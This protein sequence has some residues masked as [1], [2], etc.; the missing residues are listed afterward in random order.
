MLKRNNC[1][2]ANKVFKNNDVN[3]F[4]TGEK[5]RNANDGK[6]YKPTTFTDFR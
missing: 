5:P 3:I 4:Q 6:Q 1:P 2:T